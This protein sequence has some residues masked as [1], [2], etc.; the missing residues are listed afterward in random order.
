MITFENASLTYPGGVQALKNV[1]LKL[2]YLKAVTGGHL[3]AEGRCLRAG[4]QISYAQASVFDEAGELTRF[5]QCATDTCG[6]QSY[7]VH[8]PPR[9]F[10]VRFSQEF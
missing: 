10:G 9:S 7:T 5:A 2:N 3:R 1:D 4:R 8:S 6:T